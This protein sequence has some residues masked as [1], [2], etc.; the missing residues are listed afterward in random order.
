MNRR[1]GG[2]RL[3]TQISQVD[4][5]EGTPGGGHYRV[6]DLF[7]LEPAPTDDEPRRVE[8]QWTGERPAVAEHLPE[9]ARE[10]VTDLTRRMFEKE[11]AR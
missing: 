1:V 11:A 9:D 10:R 4:P 7:S 6:R 5:L 3:V 8:L 2:R